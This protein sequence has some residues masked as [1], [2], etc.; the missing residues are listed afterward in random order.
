MRHIFSII[1]V[2]IF[3]SCV[4]FFN[5]YFVSAGRGLKF[6]VCAGGEVKDFFVCWRGGDLGEFFCTSLT[7]FSPPPPGIKRPLPNSI[8]YLY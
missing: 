8:M 3:S 5:N 7:K 6:F 1:K 4:L 2:Y